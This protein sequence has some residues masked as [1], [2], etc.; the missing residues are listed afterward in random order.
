MGRPVNADANATRGRILESAIGMFSEHGDKSSVREI[1]R[2]ADVSLAMVHHYFGSKAGLRSACVDTMY[3]ELAELRT[4]LMESVQGGAVEEVLEQSVR[5]VFRFGRERLPVVRLLMREVVTRGAL[6]ASRRDT[7][8]LPFLDT[9]SGMLAASSGQAPSAYRLKLQSL[10]FLNG[11]YAIADE[12]ELMLVTGTDN[13]TAALA[14]VE[15]H[16]VEASRLLLF[17]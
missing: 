17:P 6:Q 4:V 2:R 8:L 7:F 16:L 3:A 1:A 11:R 12:E 5:T 9:V 15:D 13:G 14:A 10:V